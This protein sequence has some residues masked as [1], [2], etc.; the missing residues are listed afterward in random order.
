M[1]LCE[2]MDSI[3]AVQKIAHTRRGRKGVVLYEQTAKGTTK[4]HSV[5][6]YVT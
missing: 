5:V 6:S 2:I 4:E 1:E 3:K